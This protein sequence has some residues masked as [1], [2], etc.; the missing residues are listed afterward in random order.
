MII[1]GQVGAE[2]TGGPGVGLPRLN[3]SANQC[4]GGGSG[5]RRALTTLPLK[6]TSSCLSSI[7]PDY[8]FE[9][10]GGTSTI[11]PMPK[12]CQQRE[13]TKIRP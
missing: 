12:E 2:A 3:T 11:T 4:P 9:I 7:D 1:T 10:M 8:R 5:I 6:L 13:P